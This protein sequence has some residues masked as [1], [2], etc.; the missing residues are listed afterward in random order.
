MTIK[1]FENQENR[2]DDNQVNYTRLETFGDI[3]VKIVA[4]AWDF[5]VQFWIYE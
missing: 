4:D 1:Y 5:T 3:N 2:I